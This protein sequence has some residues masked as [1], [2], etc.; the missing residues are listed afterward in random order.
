MI[1]GVVSKLGNSVRKKW[2]VIQ[3]NDVLTTTRSIQ[4]SGI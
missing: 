3:Q 1:V 2:G 4:F